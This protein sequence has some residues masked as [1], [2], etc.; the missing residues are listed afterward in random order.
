[1]QGI[2]SLFNCETRLKTLYSTN[3]ERAISPHG[4]FAEGTR[5]GAAASARPRRGGRAGAFRAR[6]FSEGGGGSLQPLPGKLRK[7][8]AGVWKKQ[9][10]ITIINILPIYY[11]IIHIMES[12]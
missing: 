10:G 7:F 12:G 4:R 5:P 11:S 8:K 2:G 6:G 3:V 1:M 9:I